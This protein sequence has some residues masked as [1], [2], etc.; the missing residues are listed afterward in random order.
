MSTWQQALS[1][2]AVL[3]ASRIILEQFKEELT[4]RTV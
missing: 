1:E 3:D 4:R 2:G